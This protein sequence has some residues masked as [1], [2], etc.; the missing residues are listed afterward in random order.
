MSFGKGPHYCLGA[1]LGR[2]EVQIV[3]E[4]LTERTPAME[5]VPE[6]AFSYSP[7]A[8]FRGL[9]KLMVAPQGLAAVS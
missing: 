5:L 1:P 3:L 8:L 9:H 6:Q 4:L 2:L 7:N